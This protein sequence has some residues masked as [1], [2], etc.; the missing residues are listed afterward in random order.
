MNIAVNTRFLIKNKLE[1]IGWFTYETLKRITQQHP[2]HNFYFL[3][4]RKYSKEFIFADNVTP[5]VVP[6]PARHPF[7][8]Y[9]WFEHFIPITLNKIKAD[10]FL[11]T[12]GYIS[13]KSNVKTVNVIH[14]I[15]F[16]HYP[17]SVPFLVRKYYKHYFPKF[18]SGA[19]RLA[20]VSDYSKKDLIDKY[21]ISSDKIDVVFNGVNELYKPIDEESMIRTKT[22]FTDGKDYFLFIGGLHP[23]KN[24]E[25][26]ILAFDQFKS[27]DQNEV[28]LLIVGGKG[29]LNSG[30]WSTYESLGSKKDIII[31]EGIYEPER[32]GK[33]IASSLAI[34][35]VSYFEGFGIPIVEGMYCNIPVITSN[36][37]CMPEVAEDAALLVDP[38]SIDSISDAMFRVATEDDLRN[39]LV[40]KGK[41]Q[42]EKFTWQKT[43][44]KLW[45]CLMKA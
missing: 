39:T 43:S 16:E 18:A 22:E 17:E 34:T 29:W 33:I 2:E 13:L 23:R 8:W 19:D 31:T 14:D 36:V 5:I 7:L 26:L 35:Y 32:I 44:E 42:R 4:D 12:D 25:R 20:T 21:N 41:I 37:S 3:F 9:L 10:L 11:S 28:K 27:K 38:F 45:N 6:P 24:V 1:G 30:F 40:E 15:V